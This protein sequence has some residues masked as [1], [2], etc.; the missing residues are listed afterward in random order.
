MTK[1]LRDLRKNSWN[2]EAQELL[3]RGPLVKSD[4]GVGLCCSKDAT[5]CQHLN[6]F[7]EGKVT[8]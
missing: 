6:R 5:H 3:S 2:Q 4:S 8:G 7:H 1:N